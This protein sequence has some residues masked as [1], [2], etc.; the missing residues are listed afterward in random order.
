[1]VASLK[2]F[3]TLPTPTPRF[4]IF[5][6]PHI[7][8]QQR[9]SLRHPRA[10]HGC[11]RWGPSRN[12]SA[13]HTRAR[14]SRDTQRCQVGHEDTLCPRIPP[15][16][17]EPLPCLRAAGKGKPK[18]NEALTFPTPPRV[19]RPQSDRGCLGPG[20]PEPQR[21]EG[22]R[23]WM[24]RAPGLGQG[25]S[26]PSL[27]CPP[28]PPAD[29]SLAAPSSCPWGAMPCPAWKL[30]RASR[31]RGQ[32]QPAGGPG[33]G[34][35]PAPNRGLECQGAA[36]AGREKQPSVAGVRGRLPGLLRL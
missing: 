20:Q 30:P 10:F 34:L 1:M 5:I 24:P 29:V 33:Q 14:L 27:P 2:K 15:A 23:R 35:R 13:V 16:G 25:S 3:S 36:A 6:P 32:G 31:R 4:P 8:Q 7:Y 26:V 18:G 11:R 28:L 12:V 9:S 17:G 21:L 19:G 22:R